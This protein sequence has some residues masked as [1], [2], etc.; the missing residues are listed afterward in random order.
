MKL[1][2]AR[3]VSLLSRA[4]SSREPPRVQVSLSQAVTSRFAAAL[5]ESRS[6]Q[7]SPRSSPISIDRKEL[8]LT[9]PAPSCEGHEGRF[10]SMSHDE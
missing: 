10:G 3:D 8:T 9:K 5:T 4:L 1:V 2:S 6:S 7:N